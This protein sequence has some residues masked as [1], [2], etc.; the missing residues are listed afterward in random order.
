[1]IRKTIAGTTGRT[2]SALLLV[3]I[4]SALVGAA[5][6]ASAAVRPS[7]ASA[8]AADDAAAAA[9][10]AAA[11]DDRVAALQTALTE[12]LERIDVLSDRIS[13]I[14]NAQSEQRQVAAAPVPVPAPA[15]VVTEEVAV[16]QPM[17]TPRAPRPTPVVPATPRRIPATE[18]IAPAP[19]HRVESAPLASKA[20]IGAQIA[21]DY[22][23]ALML[24]GRGRIAESRQAFQRVFEADS[25]GELADNALYWIGETYFVG[26]DYINA[27]KYYRKVQSDYGDQ[28]KASDAVYKLGMVFEKTGDLGLAKSTFEE[29]IRKYPYSAAA[30]SSKSELKRIKY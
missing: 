5:P 26:G 15:P 7:M 6:V 23:A 28:N 9:T 17:V 14:E 22:R 16:A 3:A 29:C 25:A 24:Y 12:L 4:A 8:R 19:E 27:M 2:T 20:I 13:R 18:P 1:M 21:D 30:A 11:D 10:R